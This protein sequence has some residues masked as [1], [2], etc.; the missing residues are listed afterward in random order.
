MDWLPGRRPREK[1]GPADAH[2]AGLPG[3]PADEKHAPADAQDA[4]P[5]DAYDAGL[6]LQY[7]ACTQARRRIWCPCRYPY[8]LDDLVNGV[9]TL[10]SLDSQRSDPSV[11]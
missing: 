5:A 3:R 1:H 11:Q 6:H 8:F 9:V 4:G 7:E 2:D 10:Q